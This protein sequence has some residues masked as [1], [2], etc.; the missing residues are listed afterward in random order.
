MEKQVPEDEMVGQHHQP[1]GQESEQT[2]G[3]E[4]EEPGVL[5]STMRQRAGPDWVTERQSRT[6]PAHLHQLTS[7]SEEKR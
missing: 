1:D 5:Q 4:E 7:V 2:P 6:T 3:N